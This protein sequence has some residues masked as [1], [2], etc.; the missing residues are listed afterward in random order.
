LSTVRK[1]RVLGT[2][3]AGLFAVQ[4][5]V[6]IGADAQDPK[7][8]A[9]PVSL[10]NAPGVSGGVDGIGALFAGVNVP[11]AA[12]GQTENKWAAG[13]VFRF[14]GDPDP[15]GLI[16]LDT[17]GDQTFASLSL[18]DG[19]TIV[20]TQR[21][22]FD[23]QRDR[24]YL[25]IVV[26]L[27]GN[28]VAGF[29]YDYNAAAWTFV[30][31]V[32]AQSAWG[33][34]SPASATTLLWYGD[35]AEDC[36]LYPQADHYRYAPYA[37]EGGQVIT[38]TLTG[39][40]VLPGDCEATVTAASDPNFRRY[41]AGSATGPVASTTTSTTTQDTTTTT[42][43][44]TTT[45][46]STTSTTLLPDITLPPTTLLPTT[47]TTEATTTTTEATTTTSTVP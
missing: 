40:G 2:A 9:V 41:Q 33:E 34:L 27:P 8:Q 42:T 47:T 4:A 28:A 20:D 12:G 22:A 46:T 31:A 45:T 11:A 3:I 43:E 36:A 37:F 35:P 26:M 14:T 25:P 16:S 15:F 1:R 39:E 38:S 18:N 30:G 32:R 6:A 24:F 13:L 29:V 23:W 21:F 17:D 10:W 19:E 7:T 44:A 5:V